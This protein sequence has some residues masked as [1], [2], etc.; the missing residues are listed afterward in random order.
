[1]IPK[2]DMDYIDL[3]AEKLKC[4]NSVFN[5]HKKLI[6]SQ[7]KSSSEIFK[8]RFGK[9]AAFKKNA[10]IYLRSIKLI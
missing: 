4:D 2:T 5:Q 3:Y 8:N 1:M 7:M 6:E 9:G 10:R